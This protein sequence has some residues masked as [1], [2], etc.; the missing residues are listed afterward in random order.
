MPRSPRA[1]PAAR[2]RATC[3]R[4]L[5]PAAAAAFRAS[6]LGAAGAGRSAALAPL[7]SAAGVAA[8]EPEFQAP[9]GTRVVRDQA[10][11][12][13][14]YVIARL[15]PGVRVEAAVEALRKSAEVAQVWPIPILKVTGA[16]NDSLWPQ[17]YHLFQSSRR[18]LHALEAWNVYRGDS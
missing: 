3:P 10:S 18:D 14:E 13:D 9:A 2:R 8:F 12:L 4:R 15:T 1:V 11:H 5:T 6:A 17:S 16:P 7:A